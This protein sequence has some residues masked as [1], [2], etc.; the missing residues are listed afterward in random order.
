MLISADLIPLK[1]LAQDHPTAR[2]IDLC[3]QL[4]LT[5]FGH[6]INCRL[7]T[8]GTLNRQVAELAEI[9]LPLP[10]NI[11]NSLAAAPESVPY[12][13]NTARVDEGTSLASGISEE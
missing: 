10:K 11:W 4:Q 1:K 7:S 6:L 2:V 9:Y 3:Q 12:Y 13:F 5:S 8:A